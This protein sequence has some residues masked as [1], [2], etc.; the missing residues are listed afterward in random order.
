LNHYFTTCPRGLEAL[1]AEDL[2]KAGGQDIAT[3]PGGAGCSGSLETG[4]RIN[5]ESRIATRALWRIA[6]GGYR[7]EADVYRLAYDVDWSRLF[8]VDRSIRVYVTAI[9]SPLKSIEFNFKL[10]I[11]KLLFPLQLIFIRN[12]AHCRY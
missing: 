7:D 8:S 6:R 11:L 10:F 5:L 4:Y 9:R 2:A 12:Q 3:V 1:L